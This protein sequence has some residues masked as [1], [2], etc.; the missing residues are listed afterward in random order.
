MS[1]TTEAPVLLWSPE[2]EQ[3]VLGCMLLDPH[4][5]EA[6]NDAQLAAQHFH[7]RRNINIFAAIITLATQHKGVDALTVFEHLRTQG[8]DVRCG[9]LEYLNALAQCVPS[10]TNAG[11]YAATVV[12][13]AMRR[14]IVVAAERAITV[15]SESPSA[16]A[17]I[18]QVA[19]LFA[20]IERTRAKDAPQAIG[21]HVLRRLEHWEALAAGDA[22]PGIPTGL[23]GLDSALNGGMRPGTVI[24]LAARPSV[25]KT[26]LAT[27]VAINVTQCGHGVLLLSQEMRAGDLVDRAAANLGHLNL[28][29]VTTGKFE[30]DDWTRIT[31]VT[32]VAARLPLYI[33]D[34]PALTLLD[35]RAKVRQVQ[36]TRGLALVVIDYLQL[37][38]TTGNTASRHHGIE[39]ISRGLKTLA[40]EFELTVMVLSQLTRESGRD[41]PE[42]HHL[43]E[44]G[45]I[46]EDADVVALLHPW[47]DNGDGTTTVVLKIAKNRQGRRGRLALSFHGA[48]QRWEVSNADV[49]RGK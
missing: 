13:K 40:K 48:T 35:I 2:S 47:S 7:D 30:S 16:E 19:T 6:A 44:S 17:A 28:G 5:I 14:A 23:G 21:A 1:T 12:D 15:A 4:A 46:E 41:E 33:D 3:S 20:S 26:S 27:Q 34:T 8:Q 42:L 25:G 24:T 10:A 9:G 43:K 18:D 22:S 38:A 49:S 31:E 45:A 32:D 11:R 37:C 29:S 39:A 36:R